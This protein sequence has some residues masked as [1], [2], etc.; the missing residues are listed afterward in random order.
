RLCKNSVFTVSEYYPQSGM[1]DIPD[2]DC[3]RCDLYV[4]AERGFCS[5]IWSANG[6]LLGAKAAIPASCIVLA[7]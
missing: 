2:I 7:A 6:L 5:L 1:Q 4:E 3:I